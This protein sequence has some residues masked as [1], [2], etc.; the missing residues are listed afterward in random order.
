[1]LRE[2]MAAQGLSV[3]ALGRA[4]GVSHS[5]VSRLLAGRAR[6]TPG[7]LRAVAPAL[8]CPAHELLAA[9]GLGRTDAAD[10]PWDA[11]R[12]L[13]VDPAPPALAARVAERLEHIEAYAA[14]DAAAETV[15]TG[16][17]AKLTAIGAGGPVIERLRALGRLYLVDSDAPVAARLAAGS[18]VLYFLLAV[19]AIDD[20]LFPLGYL[21][22]AIAIALAEAKVRRLTGH[23]P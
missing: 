5:S 12:Q 11:L 9:A 7:L 19:D 18:A 8:G 4:A 2:R 3:R 22:D 10:D 14:T 13:G 21:D 16:L 6:P 15:R 20:F 17:E 1:M 23:A